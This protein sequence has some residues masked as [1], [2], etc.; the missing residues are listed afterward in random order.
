MNCKEGWKGEIHLAS[1]T[2]H[3][4]LQPSHFC[5]EKKCY[6]VIY[7]NIISMSNILDYLLWPWLLCA[8]LTLPKRHKGVA[9]APGEQKGMEPASWFCW[10]AGILYFL[11]FFANHLVALLLS[12]CAAHWL[13]TKAGMSCLSKTSSEEVGNVRQRAFLRS[14][15]QR[16][17]PQGVHSIPH[18][19]LSK[20]LR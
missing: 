3:V 18:L 17:S 16:V 15:C 8:A 20:L 7:K 9:R 2:C 6:E 13:S 1:F 19:C 12:D 10:A 14:A 11:G 5:W 4:Q